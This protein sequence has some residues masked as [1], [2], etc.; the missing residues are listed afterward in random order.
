MVLVVR[1]VEGNAH[2][3][4]LSDNNLRCHT[5][6]CPYYQATDLVTEESIPVAELQLNLAGLPV[7][8]AEFQSQLRNHS[9]A[10]SGYVARGDWTPVIGRGNVAYVTSIAFAH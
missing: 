8:E 6:P 9:L 7:T 2:P 3:Y 10:I 1:S 5:Q 4:L